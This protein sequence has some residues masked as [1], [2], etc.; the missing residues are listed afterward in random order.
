MK[1]RTQWSA[2]TLGLL[3]AGLPIEVGAQ[4]Q[5]AERPP[6][7]AEVSTAA[8][9]SIR[10]RGFGDV[11]FVA[12]D[13]AG[14]SNSFSIGQLD[15]FMASRLSQ[16]FQVLAELVFE[17][18]DDNAFVVDV[19]RL[20]LEY[21]PGD[22]LR[23]GAGRYHAGIGYY[24]TAYHH[25]SWF[26]TS[27]RRPF[28]FE[29]EDGGGILPMHGVGLV[30]RGEIPSGG[31]GLRYLVEVGNGRASRSGADEPIQNAKDE[32]DLKALNV[33]VSSR[34]AVLPELELGVG[35]YRDRLEPE[36]RSPVAET[37]LTGFAVYSSFS[38]ELLN[39]VVWIRH[40]PRAEG[41]VSTTTAFYSQLSRR[42]GRARPYSRYEYLKVPDADPIAGGLGRREALS[43]GVRLD[44]TTYASLK[45]QYARLAR[46]RSTTN[47]FEVQAA[48]AF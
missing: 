18:G 30:A 2:A 34:P 29:Y 42:W 16:R 4:N 31:V 23:L 45:A 41:E 13:A 48:F 19:E 38:L 1:G 35:L 24:N 7:T 27:A 3:L 47:G 32:N 37:I 36:G 15:L 43:L 21:S 25:G 26:E 20:L 10:L 17:A 9:P 14:K 5:A 12:T 44:L 22:Y 8:E 28:I 40:S 6:E 11:S 33:R 46:D 39:E